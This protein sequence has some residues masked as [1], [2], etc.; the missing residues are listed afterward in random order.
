M[1]VKP[2]DRG[3]QMLEYRILNKTS[4]DTLHKTFRNA[5]SDYQVEMEVSVE[6]FQQTLQRRGYVP[7]ISLV[8]IYFFLN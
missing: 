8:D 4:V 6:R 3:G 1:I 2:L 7:E 5:F